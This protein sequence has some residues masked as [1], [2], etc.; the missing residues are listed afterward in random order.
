MKA[1]VALAIGAFASERYRTGGSCKRVDAVGRRHQ[2]LPGHV[3]DLEGQQ[4]FV[5]P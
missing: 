1:L 2:L 3:N 5:G 4:P